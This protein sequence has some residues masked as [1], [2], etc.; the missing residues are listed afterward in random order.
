MENNSLILKANDEHIK[1]IAYIEKVCFNDPW[2][3]D[4][5]KATIHNDNSYTVV[6]FEDN[7]VKGY[8]GMYYA[9]FEG[10]MNNIAVLPEYRG[11]KIASKLINSLINYSKY[12]NLEFLSLEVRKSN[13]KAIQ[14]YKHFGFCIVGQRKNFYTHPVEDAVIMTKWFIKK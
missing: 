2:S 3:E 6:F 4:S 9:C 5:I 10:Y 12:N 8:A 13:S 11:K 1:S 14:I 7:M